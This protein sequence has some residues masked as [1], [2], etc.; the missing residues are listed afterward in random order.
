MHQIHPKLGPFAAMTIALF[1]SP[2]FGCAGSSGT[3]GGGGG[4]TIG[5]DAGTAGQDTGSSSG[6]T[7]DVGPSGGDNDTGGAGSSSGSGVDA[8]SEPVDAGTTTQA[9]AGVP[10]TDVGNGGGTTNPFGWGP[11]KCSTE[12]GKAGYNVGNRMGKLVLHDCDTDEPRS[13]DELCGAKATWLFVAHSHC[14]TCQQTAKYTAGVAKELAAKE[15][16]VAHVVYIDDWQNCKDWR[17]KYGL[18]GIPNLKYYV[19]KTGAAW[20]AIKTKPYTAPHAIMGKN[21][22]ITYKNHGLNS[23]GVKS[24]INLALTL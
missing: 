1:L 13:L 22:I 18:K 11:D 21:Q 24:K 7:D 9:D 2:T 4:T 16:A 6:G 5:T 15:V 14:P 23:S 3:A 10:P 20:N 19:D 8:G 12:G 17:E